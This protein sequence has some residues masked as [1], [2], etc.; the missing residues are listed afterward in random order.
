[1]QLEKKS[2]PTSLWDLMVEW[3]KTNVVAATIMGILALS[4]VALVIYFRRKNI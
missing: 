2:Q 1:M 3:V 4:S